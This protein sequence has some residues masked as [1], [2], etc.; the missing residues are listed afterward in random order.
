MSEKVNSSKEHRNFMNREQNSPDES[1][2][3]H[4]T[5]NLHSFYPIRE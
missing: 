1:V 2:F 4:Y 3:N 5:P